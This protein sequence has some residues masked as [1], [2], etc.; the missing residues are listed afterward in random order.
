ML[1]SIK[2]EADMHISELYPDVIGEDLNYEFKAA[3]S[4]DT[5]IKWAKTI[6][7]YARLS[8]LR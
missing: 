2:Q 1:F 3:L 4:E 5:P 7:A 6:V 8:H